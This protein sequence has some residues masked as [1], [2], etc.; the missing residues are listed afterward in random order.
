MLNGGWPAKI[1]ILD[2]T[3]ETSWHNQRWSKFKYCERKRWVGPA[4]HP[5][6][7]TPLGPGAAGG[8]DTAILPPIANLRYRRTTTKRRR[9]R[10]RSR[11]TKASGAPLRPHYPS[12]SSL[13]HYLD[14]SAAASAS[15]YNICRGTTAP[16]AASPSSSS[17]SN[18]HHCQQQELELLHKVSSLRKQ[19]G[20]VAGRDSL[21]RPSANFGSSMEMTSYGVGAQSDY[22]HR[23]D[24]N[25]Y[26][27]L[28]YGI[29]RPN[30]DMTNENR[31]S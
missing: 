27:P 6:S 31:R 11:T 28:L 17:S 24:P 30:F 20:A 21:S 25:L 8:W 15:Y 23:R 3:V 22:V 1:I 4:A 19:T 18:Q 9:R 10:E 29:Q 14:S 13:L 7:G 26:H 12:R 5:V 16:A 2:T